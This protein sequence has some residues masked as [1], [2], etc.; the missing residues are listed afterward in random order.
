MKRVESETKKYVN[1][2]TPTAEDRLIVA[3]AFTAG[4]RKAVFDLHLL[5]VCVSP[6][7]AD[8]QSL[9]S[10][11]NEEIKDADSRE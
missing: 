5:G 2:A 11:V 10:W 7:S 8:S 6:H 1:A 3:T 9:L 4:Y